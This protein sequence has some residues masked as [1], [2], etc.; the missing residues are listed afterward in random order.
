MA[1]LRDA[2]SGILRP[3]DVG[4]LIVQPIQEASVA[5]QV[6]T[7][8]QSQASEFRIPVIE[9]DSA[10][11]W[12]PEGAEITPS[13]PTVFEEIVRPQAVKGLTKVST[14]LSEDSSPEAAATVGQGLARSVARKID[15]A[16]FGNTTTNGPDGLRSL[17]AVQIVDAGSTFGNVDPFLEA[18]SLLES[19]G[20][21]ATAFCASA[22]TVL[23]LAQL[24]EQ[25][26]SNKPLLQPDPTQ[27]VRRTIQGV[28]LWSLPAGVIADGT[29]WALDKAK[30]FAV[31]RRDVTLDVDPSFYFGSD[32]LAV[33]VTCRVGFGFPHEEAIVKVGAG[34]S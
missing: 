6:C 13:D 18:I 34:G 31:M 28:P 4:P 10:A 32:S 20:S 26:G 15:T 9:A 12:T 8:V 21:T 14:E 17:G 16:F 27:P 23:T 11:E 29:V 5:L 24:K 1:L 22:A 7:L 33:R 2:A 3:E 19:V 30:V 25:A